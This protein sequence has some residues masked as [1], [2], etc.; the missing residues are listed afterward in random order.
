MLELKKWIDILGEIGGIE[1]QEEA[2]RKEENIP[3][4]LFEIYQEQKKGLEALKAKYGSI[5]TVEQIIEGV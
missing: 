5:V 3:A 4:R 1:N 2:Y